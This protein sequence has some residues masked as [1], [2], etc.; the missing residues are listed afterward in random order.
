[1]MNQAQVYK[2]FGEIDRL[3]GIMEPRIGRWRAWP[4]AKMQ[5]FWHLMYPPSNGGAGQRAS[6]MAVLGERLSRLVHDAS[7]AVHQARRLRKPAPASGTIAMMYV[8]RVHRFADGHSRDMI[9]GDLLQGHGLALPTVGLEQPWPHRVKHR[10]SGAPI[11][12][13]P[14]QSAAQLLALPLMANPNLRRSVESLDRILARAQIPIDALDRRRKILLALATF[15]SR[16]RI[17]RRLWGR[18]GVRCLV[19]TYGPGRSGEIAAAREMGISVVEFQHGVMS[20]DCPDYGWPAEY[21]PMKLDMALPDRIALFGSVFHREILR[22]GF[23][24]ESEAIP[25][26]AATMEH[27]RSAVN[28]RMHRQG[29]LRL[30]FMTQANTRD[31]AVGFW[32]EFAQAP[33]NAG[34]ECT[35][36]LKP[37]PEEEKSIAP[38]CALAK[39]FPGRFELLPCDTNP[40]EAMINADIV[41][42]YN[43][44][45]LVEALGLGKPAVSICG[46]TTPTGLAGAIGFQDVVAAVPHIRSPKEL[47]EL[48]RER[49]SSA[50]LD[51]WYAEAWRHGGA[52]F[53]DGF[54]PAATALIN[55]LVRRGGSNELH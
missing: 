6:L 17:F 27:Y 32:R 10:S 4:M 3:P 31:A 34:H 44:L 24:S 47:R 15:E 52:F 19:V 36:V 50:A 21:G 51:Q 33:K 46:G 7:V 2:L 22:T 45:A 20:A 25:I 42:A 41:V 12:L 49:T 18:L 13:D 40:I 26:G 38:Y 39:G 55:S 54:T 43:S 29:P 53:S 16:R 48:L 28:R 30:L 1:M 35:V 14:Y 8:P 37:H 23:W 9:Y 5:L 11:H